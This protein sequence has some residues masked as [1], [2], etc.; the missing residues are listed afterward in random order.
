[1]I[2]SRLFQFSKPLLW[3]CTFLSASS[4]HA[5]E[6][7]HDVQAH[8]FVSQSLVYT[9]DNNLGGNSDD[10][11]ASAIRELGANLSWRPNP[12]WLVSGQ[13]LARWAGESDEGELR[14]DY[15]FVDR[16]LVAD[17][18]KQIGIRLGKIKN[19]YGF[20][21]T[22]RDVAHTRPGVVMPQSIYLDRMRNFF[23]AAP[24]VSLYGNQEDFNTSFS[25]QVS[26]LRPEVSDDDL[27][28]F[29]LGMDAGKFKGKNSWLGQA[30]LELGGGRWRAGISLGEMAMGYQPGPVGDPYLSGNHRLPTWVLSF[31]HNTEDWSA[32]AEYSQ[33]EV[34]TR[35]YG[36]SLLA[37]FIHKG[38]TTE[39]WYVQLTRRFTPAWQG[40]LRYDVLY[41]NK[42]DR[43]GS[44]FIQEP[45]VTFSGIPSYHRFAKDWT[46]G[47]RYDWNAWAFSAEWHR[48]DGTAWISELDT[49]A[50]E[51]IRHWDMLLMQAAWRF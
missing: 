6:L 2:R 30:M 44:A 18:E 25:W 27:T 17:G 12:D 7:G 9:S 37:D 8:G 39:A 35:G 34:K 16:T 48:V 29:M 23:L 33:T 21:N 11:L 38:T 42:D 22:T 31:E 40:Y 49:P 20:S 32:T 3:L 45:F 36:A 13:A 19:P 14:L 47:I 51:S 5:Q 43:N 26:A 4:A 1:M 46:V 15:G 41:L 28:N 10:G 50:N 24:G